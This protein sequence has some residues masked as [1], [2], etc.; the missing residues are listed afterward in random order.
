MK[1][2]RDDVKCKVWFEERLLI[3]Y[4]HLTNIFVFNTLKIFFAA[5]EYNSVAF[6]ID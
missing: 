4:L 3:H 5:A 2:S 1:K 6:S